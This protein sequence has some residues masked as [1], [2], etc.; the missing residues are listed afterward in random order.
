MYV[1]WFCIS[2]RCL[3]LLIQQNQLPSQRAAR[4]VEAGHNN[5]SQIADTSVAA[6]ALV[7]LYSVL[8]QVRY[9]INRWQ[10]RWQWQLVE[11]GTHVVPS[12]VHECSYMLVLVSAYIE[13]H[14]L[15]TMLACNVLHGSGRLC[16]TATGAASHSRIC[17]GASLAWQLL[18]TLQAFAE[19]MQIFLVLKHQHTYSYTGPCSNAL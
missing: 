17:C 7:P 15:E 14:K 16:G 9:C 13:I 1:V 4:P 12:Y 19:F 5:K 8:F 18:L 6:A 3:F 11:R 2:F 10:R